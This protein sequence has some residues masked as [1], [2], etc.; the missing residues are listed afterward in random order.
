MTGIF[1][2][3]DDTL[4]SRQSLLLKAAR[5]AS[6]REFDIARFME[7]FCRKSNENFTL[8]EHGEIT[9]ASSNVW[10]LNETLRAMG[11]P[12]PEGTGERFAK[13]YTALQNQ[14][15][16]SDTLRQ[17]FEMLSKAS[18]QNPPALYLGILT[19]GES[20]HQ[21]A[22]F[23]QL[24]LARWISKSHVVISGEVGCSKPDRAIFEICQ[25]RCGLK[26][27][28]LWMIGDSPKHDICGAA[29]AGWNSVWFDRLPE[30]STKPSAA[31]N[32][33]VR[34][35]EE[36]RAYVTSELIPL[37]QKGL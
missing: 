31:C 10:R 13:I 25:E 20:S 24:S 34:S 27:K 11:V 23:Q 18:G 14:I 33:V 26:G 19:N 5:L 35:D 7:I 17:M 15:S 3:I 16:L 30:R 22:K 9:A 2:D 6:G 37:P 36:L 12:C 8:V 32:A 28:D 4:Y 1:F 29:S 21:R